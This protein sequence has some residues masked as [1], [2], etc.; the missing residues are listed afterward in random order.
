MIIAV[1]KGTNKTGI[2]KE[3]V[4]KNLD[5]KVEMVDCQISFEECLFSDSSVTCMDMASERESAMAIVK[6]PPRTT[7]FEC[8]EAFKPTIKP[9]VVI[10]PEVMPKENP[11]FHE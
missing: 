4:N 7:S 5:K 6:I 11:T 10:I 1:V 3:S 9:R 2:I 8:V